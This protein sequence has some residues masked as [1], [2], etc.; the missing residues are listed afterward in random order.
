MDIRARDVMSKDPTAVRPDTPV[1]E[2]IHLFRVSHYSGLPVVD[3]A[4]HA[5]GLISETDV[6]RALAYAIAPPGSGEFKVAFAKGRLGVTQRLLDA[7]AGREGV[8]ALAVMR[9]LLTRTVGELMSP[10]VHTCHEGDS[11]AAVC[12]MLVWKE[13]HRVVVVDEQQRVVGLVTSLD[14]VRAFGELLREKEKGGA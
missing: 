12:E 6:L 9:E 1:E 7:A 2:L 14:A 8:E 4:G 10:V 5:V 3:E 13:I 11:L